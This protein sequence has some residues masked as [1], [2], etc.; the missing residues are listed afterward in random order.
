MTF[1]DVNENCRDITILYLHTV[2]QVFSKSHSPS[3]K[4]MTVKIP[5]ILFILEP[6]SG[7]KQ[8]P[9]L[10]PVDTP[11]SGPGQTCNYRKCVCSLTITMKKSEGKTPEQ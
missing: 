2:L 11:W 10:M 5:D 3:F 4:Q 9:G 6:P 7:A 8:V 1:L